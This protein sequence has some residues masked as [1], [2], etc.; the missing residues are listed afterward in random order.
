MTAATIEVTD[1][2]FEEEVL[3]SDIPVLLDLWAPWCGRCRFV[4]PILEELADENGG[5]IKV[6][7]LNV[8][9]NPETAGSLG[10]TGIPTVVYF[11]GG[12]ELTELRTIGVRSKEDYQKAIEKA[13]VD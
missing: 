6:C 13:A 2:G 7:K 3:R 12:K 8:D 1:A 11:K 4:S 5:K 9:D 10:V